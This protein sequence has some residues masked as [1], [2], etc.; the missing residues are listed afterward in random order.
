MCSLEVN[1]HT[2][3]VVASTL[4]NGGICP[5]TGEQVISSHA[6]RDALTLMHSCGMYDYSGQF[7]FH[8]GLPAKSGISGSTMIVVPNVMGMC[9]WSPPLDSYGNSVRAIQFCKELVSVFNFHHFDNLRHVPHKKD[10][11]KQ[12]FES[13]GHQI[14]SLLFAAGNGDVSAIRRYIL[15]SDNFFFF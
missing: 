12:K 7:A 3:S 13:R 6:V 14:I 2:L 4:A 11:R 5:I 8:V 1:C 15:L 10:P 9:L